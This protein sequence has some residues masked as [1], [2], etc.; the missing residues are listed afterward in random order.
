MPARR[1]IVPGAMPSRDQ[2]GRALPALLRFYVRDTNYTTPATVYLNEALSTPAPFPIE[3]DAAGRF[4]SLWAEQ[5]SSFDVAWSDQVYDRQI[6]AF[7]AVTPIVPAASLED[8]DEAAGLAAASASAAAGSASTASTAAATA[9]TQ[10]GIATTQAGI[11]TT[12]A[13]EASDNATLIDGVPGT[14]DLFATGPLT[15]LTSGAN[16]ATVI[17][18]GLRA[19]GFTIPAGQTGVNSIII[20]RMEMT[21][22]EIAALVGKTIRITATYTITS[23]FLSAKTFAAG[24]PVQVI[25]AGSTN[26]GTLISNTANGTTMTRVADYTV[27]ADD[28]AIGLRA[29]IASSLSTAADYN[30]QLATVGYV[31]RPVGAVDV[32][33]PIISDRAIKDA[34][35]ALLGSAYNDTLPGVALSGGAT[36]RNSGGRPI[37]FTVPAGQT[38]GTSYIIPRLPLSAAVRAM[39]H[40]KRIRISVAGNVNA[41]WARAVG[42]NAQTAQANGTTRTPTGFRVSRNQKIGT[43]WFGEFSF[44]L[45]GDEYFLQP[46]FQNTSGTAAQDDFLEITD[47]SWDLIGPA[48]DASLEQTAERVRA[49]R[50]A[51]RA[52]MEDLFDIAEFGVG[53]SNGAFIRYDP[54]G[55]MVGLTIPS[56]NATATG[57]VQPFTPL[58]GV[59]LADIAG[60]VHR[61]RYVLETNA[62]WA[63]TFVVSGSVRTT[64][65]SRSPGVAPRINT[66]GTIITIEFEITFVAGDL[67][68]QVFL[69]PSTGSAAQDDWFVFREIRAEAIQSGDAQRSLGSVNALMAE[70]RAMWNGADLAIRL[71]RND[72]ASLKVA[73]LGGDYTTASA[74]FAAIYD[75]KRYN[76][77]SVVVDGEIQEQGLSTKSFVNPTGY[78]AFRSIVRGHLPANT[79]LA[80]IQGVST[81]DVRTTAR[82]SDLAVYAQNERYTF[83]VDFVTLTDCDVVFEDMIVEHLGNQE[84]RDYQTSIGGNP[85]GVWNPVHPFGVGTWSGLSVTLRRVT[86][87]GYSGFYAHSNIDFAKPATILIENCALIGNGASDA[88]TAF[89]YQPLGA[90][91]TN[92]VTM[93]GNELRGVVAFGG[94]SW[95]SDNPAVR[96]LADH[97]VD[98]QITGF[99]NAPAPYVYGDCISRALRIESVS[100]GSPSSISV[101]GAAVAVLFGTVIT[102]VSGG[103]IQGAVYGTQDVGDHSLASP[104]SVGTVSPVNPRLS[105]WLGNRT[106][107][108]ISMDVIVDGGSPQTVTFASNY[109]ASSNTTILAVINGQLTGATAS[110][111]DV[112]AR[113]R[114]RFTDEEIVVYNS[115]TTGIR[116]KRAVARNGDGDARLMTNSDSASLFLGIAL[117]RIAPGGYGRVKIPGKVV[118]VS[119]D[120][121][122]SDGASFV[123]G[124][125]FGVSNSS[126]QLAK[127]VTPTVAVAINAADVRLGS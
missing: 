9:T 71:D 49:L 65:G 68:A 94:S 16:G 61:I 97:T 33:L 92:T 13:V 91:V 19:V 7:S 8:I 54:R 77:Y 24:T 75:A 109:S 81:F 87:K 118:R 90:G 119:V 84:A 127:G 36:V 95:G 113:M 43:R 12:K 63:R 122:R 85:G 22:E 120:F 11:A 39:L 88:A 105:Y 93:I 44:M 38:G 115:G 18:A 110:L 101:T 64:G 80:T 55:R 89:Q 78:G 106:G 46:Y 124:D 31:V 98:V 35:R 26:E 1:L 58:L 116:Q 67:G 53:P 2:N 73:A 45:Q 30:I 48:S 125:T 79:A 123:A 99:G 40:G 10:A 15:P 96:Y 14:G 6:G 62:A 21:P 51:E 57:Y 3:S 69:T 82:F 60:Q 42:I 102:D 114:P 100:T 4:P 47:W 76:P 20:A 37:G 23:G 108:P 121:D 52:A 32:R 29:N 34:R 126:G 103:G 59:E 5:T 83:H 50:G 112:S 27:T 86:S 72:A 28:L 107:T 66:A 70:R 56:G 17:N 104:A 74:A 111:M 25:R 117:E 41:D